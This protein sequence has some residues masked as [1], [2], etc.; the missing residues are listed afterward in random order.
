MKA[1][2]RERH[3]IKLEGLSLEESRRDTN[4]CYG[5]ELARLSGQR[6]PQLGLSKDL[7]MGCQRDVYRVRPAPSY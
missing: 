1:T 6:R 4:P 2:G 5:T 7:A 3:M